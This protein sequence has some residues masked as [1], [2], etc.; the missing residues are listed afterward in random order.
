[1]A[2]KYTVKE[3]DTLN[4]IAQQ[5]GFSN[6]QSAGVSSVPS[7]NF[8]LIRPGETVEMANYTGAVPTIGQTPVVISSKDKAAGFSSNSSEL[9]GKMPPPTPT[10]T[11]AADPNVDPKTGRPLTDLEKQQQEKVKGK[12]ASSGNPI[13]DALEEEREKKESDAEE[14]AEEQ[15]EAQMQ[16][17][18]TSLA[19]IDST[20]RATMSNIENTY[21]AS[22]K[23]QK[24]INA[25]NIGR[26]KAY[27]LASGNAMTAPLE[28][29]N[30]VSLR[31]SQ[32]AAEIA[33]LDNLRLQ[34]IAAAQ[35]ARD[36]G[37]A[38]ALQS[39]MAQIRQIEADMRKHIADIATEATNRFNML[40]KINEEQLAKQKEQ[41][42]ALLAQSVLENFEDFANE[43]DPKKQD[44]MIREMVSKSGGL[45]QYGDVLTSLQGKA[46]AA[47]KEKR[48]AEAHDSKMATD[49]MERAYKGAQIN[50][51]NADTSKKWLEYSN[52]KKGLNADGTMPEGGKDGAHATINKLMTPGMKIN[53]VEVLSGNY[54]TPA[55]FKEITRA[56]AEDKITRKEFLE[57]YGAY[58]NPQDYDS[59]GL[60]GAE[61]KNITGVT[62]IFAP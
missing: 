28:F 2:Y 40:T 41:A 16:L 32:A 42:A 8:N 5:H 62:P 39:N 24:R 1:M 50:N 23:I 20:Y 35:A 18:N 9:D 52:M 58:L 57:Q 46:A 30:A 47:T 27:G 48:D 59:Y 51:E 26:T 33:K 45:L 15:R 7:G 10:G 29:T 11:G 3:G 60:T 53:G 34:S 21:S 14:A 38:Q 55:A 22:M 17:L 36:S 61:K 4:S 37:N 54:L 44:A 31:E 56:A 13:F 12:K 6:Y 43:K 49:K 25:L 19:A